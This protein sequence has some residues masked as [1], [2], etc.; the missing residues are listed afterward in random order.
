MFS[1]RSPIHNRI[2]ALLGAGLATGGRVYYA[3][4]LLLMG[5]KILSEHLCAAETRKDRSFRAISLRETTGL[6][7]YF[8]I[9][10]T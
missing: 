8:S 9:S 1:M 6:F 7:S 10:M 4:F 5:A 3:L 2:C